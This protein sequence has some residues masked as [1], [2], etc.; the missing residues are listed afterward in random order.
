MGAIVK[1]LH[2]ADWQMGMA[3]RGAGEKASNVRNARYESARA[4]VKVA[5]EQQVDFVLI[6]G[7]TFEHENVG[8]GVVTRTVEI[9]N[10]FAPLPV[11]VLPGNHDPLRPGGIWLQPAWKAVREHVHLCGEQQEISLP[12]EGVLYPCPLKQKQSGTDPTAW[13]PARVQGDERIRI[14]LAHG[15]LTILPNL[16]NFPIAH[17]RPIRTGLDYLALGDWHGHRKEGRAVYSGTHEQTAIDETEPGNVLVVKVAHFGAEPQIEKFRVGR[18]LWRRFRKDVQSVDDVAELRREVAALSVPD[19]LF[20]RADVHLHTANPEVVAELE[21]VQQILSQTLF[22]LDW[23]VH[24]SSEASEGLETLSAG[25]LQK[26]DEILSE[27]QQSRIPDQQFRFAA[28]YS[29]EVV[30]EARRQLHALVREARR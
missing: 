25:N 5:K 13:I 24:T 29:S 10:D 3:A 7:D 18:L 26:L 22:L 21:T 12:M 11:Y 15:G 16:P 17:D 27:I 28:A 4:I 8:N 2:T 14:G 20:L 1:F 23:E 9:L 6:A 30:S 19:Q